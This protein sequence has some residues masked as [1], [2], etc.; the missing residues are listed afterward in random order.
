MYQCT[1]AACEPQPEQRQ[2]LKVMGRWSSERE[3]YKEYIVRDLCRMFEFRWWRYEHR[4]RREGWM[5]SILLRYWLNYYEEAWTDIARRISHR[6]R[7]RESG[8]LY[9]GI[10]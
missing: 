9:C 3:G 4:E 8:M 10:L 7:Q 6:T 2:V 5:N 1:F